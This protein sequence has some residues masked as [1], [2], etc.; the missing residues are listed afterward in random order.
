VALVLINL[1]PIVFA[2]VATI[3]VVRVALVAMHVIF[4][5]SFAAALALVALF[6]P[7][8]TGRATF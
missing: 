4:A 1:A 6:A 7:R 3:V 2:V 5:L 8:R